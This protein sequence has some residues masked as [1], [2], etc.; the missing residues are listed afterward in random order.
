M[1]VVFRNEA[2]TLTTKINSIKVTLMG[3]ENF[4]PSILK[5]PEQSVVTK[6]IKKFIE[7][8]E[9]KVPEATNLLASSATIQRN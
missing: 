1:V 7:N 9:K 2:Q 8:F 5:Y 4:K 6:E 3:S